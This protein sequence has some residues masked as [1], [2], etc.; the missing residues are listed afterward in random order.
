MVEI[1]RQFSENKPP[2]FSVFENGGGGRGERAVYIFDYRLMPDMEKPR[3]FYYLNIPNSRR[4]NIYGNL[5][6]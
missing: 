2:P 5:P 6:H 4:H 3:F 1:V